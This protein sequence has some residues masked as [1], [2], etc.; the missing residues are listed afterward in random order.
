MRLDGERIVIEINTD[1]VIAYNALLFL[2]GT[3]PEE[4][5]RFVADDALP[6]TLDEQTSHDVI[7]GLKSVEKSDV[8]IYGLDRY[9]ARSYLGNLGIE[10]PKPRTTFRQADAHLR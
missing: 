10:I 2:R 8:N 5:G 7:E 6:I 1:N 3:H 9:Y 4:L